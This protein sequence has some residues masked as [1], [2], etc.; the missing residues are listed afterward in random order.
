MHDWLIIGAMLLATLGLSLAFWRWLMP[1][2]GSESTR[3][4][5]RLAVVLGF[6]LVLLA[7]PVLA[8]LLIEQR[9]VGAVCALIIGWAALVRA[10]AWFAARLWLVPRLRAMREAEA[11]ARAAGVE[12]ERDAGGTASQP[13]PGD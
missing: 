1:R 13:Q 12:A 6:G 11:Q 4:G 5:V 2:L 7:L 9:T 3:G 8:L 10:T